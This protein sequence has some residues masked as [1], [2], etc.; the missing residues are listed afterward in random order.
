MNNLLISIIIFSGDKT[1]KKAMLLILLSMFP[2]TTSASELKTPCCVVKKQIKKSTPT[3]IKASPPPV[4]NSNQDLS[5]K[6]ENKAKS[7]ST[8]KTKSQSQAATGNQTIT[9]NM[10]QPTKTLYKTKK[11]IKKVTINKTNPN[12]LQLLLGAS[13]SKP[14]T[15]VDDCKCSVTVK[16]A[17]EPDIG[18]QYLR[19]FSSFTGSVSA[20]KNKNV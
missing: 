19:D 13:N 18:V 4:T 3:I 7:F 9:I 10:P 2:Y 16:K 1:M 20:T 17:Y 11:I 5:T 8:S 6:G 15:V 12:R 14:D